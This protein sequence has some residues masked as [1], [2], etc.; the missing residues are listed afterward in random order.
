MMTD[1]NLV[2]SIG[3]C[4]ILV[5]ICSA[6][7]RHKYQLFELSNF[8]T[9]AILLFALPRLIFI[10]I[11]IVFNKTVNANEYKLEISLGIALLIIRCVHEILKILKNSDIQQKKM[12]EQTNQNNDNTTTNN[13]Q[14]IN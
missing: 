5:V 6:L 1:G 9:I 3:F 13:N 14:N 7:I 11:T 2:S 10:L 12:D 8:A 4:L